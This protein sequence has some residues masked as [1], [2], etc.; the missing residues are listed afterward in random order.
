MILRLS[1]LIM[2]TPN[3]C[4]KGNTLVFKQQLGWRKSLT[5]LVWKE[6]LFE[7]TRNIKRLVLF[8]QKIE[9]PNEMQVDLKF[10]RFNYLHKIAVSWHLYI[11]ISTVLSSRR[12]YL[13]ISYLFVIHEIEGNYHWTMGNTSDISFSLWNLFN[14][15]FFN[16]ERGKL[17]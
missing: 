3:S 5:F 2:A 6:S 7:P 8:E 9:Y 4:A 11:L 13:L 1:Q 17:Y 14:D 15:D 10:V 16:N 12:S